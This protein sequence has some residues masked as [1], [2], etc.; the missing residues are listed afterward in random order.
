MK[1]RL[2]KVVLSL[3]I[4]GYIATWLIAPRMVKNSCADRADRMYA[5]GL[6]SQEDHRQLMLQFGQD[7][8]ELRPRVNPGGPSVETGLAIPILPGVLLLRNSYTIG[9]LWGKGQVS[10]FLFYGFGVFRLLDFTTWIS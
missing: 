10:V 2:T 5:R 7:P 9:R 3:V 1:I 8:N 4:L 6:K